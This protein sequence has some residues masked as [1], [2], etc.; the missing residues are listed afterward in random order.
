MPTCINV[1]IGI[2]KVKNVNMLH[3]LGSSD[4]VRI[5]ENIL[6]HFNQGCNLLKVDGSS[7]VKFFEF[8]TDFDLS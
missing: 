8:L 4:A 1:Y 5:F 3:L 6:N 2:E 7:Q